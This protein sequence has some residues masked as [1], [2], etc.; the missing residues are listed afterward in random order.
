[1]ETGQV[2]ETVREREV[3][4]ESERKREKLLKYI[5]QNAFNKAFI[6]T[7]VKCNFGEGELKHDH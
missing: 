6:D 1:M 5:F 4:A 3:A 2:R 7:G